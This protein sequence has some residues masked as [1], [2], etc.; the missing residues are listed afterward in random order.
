M[1]KIKRLTAALLALVMALSLAA[2]GSSGTKD[3]AG[4]T[5]GTDEETPEYVYNTEFDEIISDS[6]QYLNPCFTPTTAFMPQAMKRSASAST[7]R[8][9]PPATTASTTFT[10]TSST[11]SIFPAR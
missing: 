10:R 3:S 9:S 1:K 8:T 5:S 2:C 4:G 11:L 6:K 7:R